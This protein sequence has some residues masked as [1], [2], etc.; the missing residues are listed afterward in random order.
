MKLMH[1]KVKLL[2]QGYTARKRQSWDVKPAVWCQASWYP[3]DGQLVAQ[4]QQPALRLPSLC[5]GLLFIAP[6]WAPHSPLLDFSFFKM[7]IKAPEY[8]SLMLIT[9]AVT[10]DTSFFP[11]LASYGDRW[12]LHDNVTNGHHELLKGTQKNPGSCLT[13][14]PSREALQDKSSEAPTS[15]CDLHWH[16]TLSWKSWPGQLG[17]KQV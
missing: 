12:V 10:L 13:R 1:W 14:P 15:V 3:G 11:G 2:A 16:L 4:I 6:C 17:R 9:Q 8:C 5:L 7:L